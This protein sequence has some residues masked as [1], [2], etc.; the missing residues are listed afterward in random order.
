MLKVKARLFNRSCTL[1]PSK[2]GCCSDPLHFWPTDGRLNLPQ[3]PTNALISDVMHHFIWSNDECDIIN[4]L[5]CWRSTH[6][7][8]NVLFHCN[9]HMLLLRTYTHWACGGRG[10]EEK[11]QKPWT[12]CSLNF[13]TRHT[14]LCPAEARWEHDTG[15]RC[16]LRS[17]SKTARIFKSC[18][19]YL[20]RPPPLLI[21][22]FE[23]MSAMLQ[24]TI[25]KTKPR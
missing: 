21:H 3:A 19:Y 18:V 9:H 12:F 2:P 1:H 10:H 23:C 8:P 7:R 22:S 14:A 13:S 6:T 11:T 16:K 5:L 15:Q 17:W 24:F 25:D 4:R 20:T